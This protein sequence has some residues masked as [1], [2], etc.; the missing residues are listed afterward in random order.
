MKNQQHKT[1][2]NMKNQDDNYQPISKLKGR[3]FCDL[4]DKVFKIVVLRNNLS[5]KKTEKQFYK[6]RKKMHEQNENFDKEIGIIKRS[7]QIL[8]S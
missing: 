1:I 6:M 4:A 5:H 8:Q 7:K 3:Q 2:R